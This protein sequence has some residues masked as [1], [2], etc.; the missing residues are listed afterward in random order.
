M[1]LSTVALIIAGL[2]GATALAQPVAD[3]TPARTFQCIEPSGQMAPAVCDVTASRL[4][5][6]EKICTCPAGGQRVEVAI[7]AKGQTPPAD[8]KA[9]HQARRTAARDGTLVGDT[10]AGQPIC[11]PPRGG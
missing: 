6:R 11:A 10:V 1:R 2:T 8:N 9:L 4:N 3:P 7:C 5:P